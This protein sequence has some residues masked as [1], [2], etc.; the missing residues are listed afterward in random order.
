MVG[1]GVE[2]IEWPQP[3]LP[4]DTLRAVSEIVELR[5][6]RSKPD[7]G[8]ARIRTTTFNQRDEPVQV[9]TSLQIVLRRPAADT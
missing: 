6:S 9:M 7:R 8:F 5:L 4:G 1:L 3:V 2:K